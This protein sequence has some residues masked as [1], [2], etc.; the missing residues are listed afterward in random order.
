METNHLEQVR[1]KLATLKGKDLA[2]TAQR[3]G[4]SYDTVLRIRDGTT[5]HPSYSLVMA[6]ERA[7]RRR[8]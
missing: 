3:V 6:L 8:K 2:A 4:A 1:A 7:L 5:A